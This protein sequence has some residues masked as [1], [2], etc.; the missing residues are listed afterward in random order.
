VVYAAE[1]AIQRARHSVEDLHDLVI[2]AIRVLNDAELDSAKARLTDRGD[3]YVEAASEHM[4]RLQTRCGDMAEVG[5]E[6]TAQLARAAEIASAANGVL[7]QD[8]GGV[9]ADPLVSEAAQLGPRIAVLAEMVNLARP[10]AELAADHVAGAR[11]ASLEL[12]ASALLGPR[13]LEHS[14][15]S[16]GRELG[17]ADEDIRLLETVVDRAAASARQCDPSLTGIDDNARQ[18]MV[19]TQMQPAS[20][21]LEPAG[22]ALAR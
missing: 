17:R 16:A 19:A 21:S 9:G 5:A 20:A 15:C 6:L 11:S 22:G 14:I 18:R 12:T 13:S 10:M 4:S 2:S 7:V 3:F 8:L 1:Q